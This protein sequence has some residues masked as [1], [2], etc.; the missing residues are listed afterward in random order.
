[1]LKELLQRKAEIEEQIAALKQDLGEVMFDIQDM[2][3]LQLQEVRFLQ[4]KETGSVNITVDGIK[5]TETIPK[6]VDWDQ[7]KLGEL[8]AK[9]MQH[10]DKPSNYMRMSLEVPEKMY[11]AMEPGIKDL[12]AEARTVKNGK[13]TYKFEEAE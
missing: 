13:A 5:I 12:F 9:I 7:D 4:A 2:L 11:E 10:G 1:M 8:F 6:R 3:A